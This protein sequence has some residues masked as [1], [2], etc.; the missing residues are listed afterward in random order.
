MHIR[1]SAI[2]EVV[3]QPTQLNTLGHTQCVWNRIKGYYSLTRFRSLFDRVFG[4]ASSFF[5][6]RP[7]SD[8]SQR[9]LQLTS[10]KS[11]AVLI[12]VNSDEYRFV[13]VLFSEHYSDIFD[14]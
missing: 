9:Q 1:N 14:L 13:F 4:I 8:N 6:L 3:D 7:G 11:K 5:E 10:N 2:N 12:D